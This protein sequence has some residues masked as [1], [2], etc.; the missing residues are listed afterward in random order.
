MNWCKMSQ[1]LQILST[2]H[3]R[4]HLAF[5]PSINFVNK[6]KILNSLDVQTVCLFIEVK[7][8][9]NLFSKGGV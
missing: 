5:E 7:D 2:V 4:E 9:I 6:S 8:W 3:S 1:N